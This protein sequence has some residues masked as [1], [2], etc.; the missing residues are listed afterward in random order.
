L[1]TVIT[2]IQIH[3]E[4]ITTDIENHDKQTNTNQD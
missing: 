4:F 1:M 3:H 2:K